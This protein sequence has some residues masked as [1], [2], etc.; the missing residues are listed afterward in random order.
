MSKLRVWMEPL[1]SRFAKND[2]SGIRRV[3]EAYYKYLPEFDIEFV[4]PSDSCDV[5]AIHAGMAGPECDV[6]H[7]HGLYW[8]ADYPAQSWEWKANRNVIQTLYHAKR[9]TVPS[10]WVAE[11]LQRDMRFTPHVVGHGIDWQAWQ[12]ND[13]YQKYVLW[14]KNRSADVCSPEPVS[15]LAERFPDINFVA[16]FASNGAPSNIQ[17]TGV[18]PHP[19]MKRLVQQ[20]GI[21]LATT[22]ETFGIGTLE[23]MA[24]GV[25]V[26]GFRWGGTA[27]LVQHGVNGYL[28]DPLDYDDLA[29]GLAY[30]MQ[31][32]DTLGQNGALLAQRY[33]WREVAAQLADIY[34]LAAVTEPP[35]V[36]VIVPVYNKSEAALL[37][38]VK[39]ALAQTYD[40]L[41]RIIVIDD[42]STNG[43]DYEKALRELHDGSV[44]YQ[45]KH[46]GGVAEARNFGIGLTD[47]KYICCLDADDAIE[48]AF[49]ETCVKAL[50][51]DRTLG[52]AYTALKWVKPD[53]SEGIS[54]WPGEYDYNEQLKRK[55]QVPC[56]CVYKRE[57]WS[58]LGGYKGRYCPRGA[59]TEDAEFWT[60]AGA[61]GY[62]AERV[63]AEPLFVY[64]WQNPESTTRQEG[65]YEVDWLAWHPWVND[66][67]HPL[68]SVATPPRFAHPVREYD[69][70]E[71]SVIIPV[72]P[73]HETHVR[74]ALDSLEAQ[75]FRNW[76]AIVVYD[77]AKA[78]NFTATAYPYTHII[79]LDENHGA[80]Y[81]RNRGAEKARAK[82]LLFLDADDILLP[83]A[84][85]AM[86]DT[87]DVTQ[88]A[89]YTDHLGAAIIDDISA[90]TEGERGNVTFWDNKTGEI[91]FKRRALDFDCD[92]AAL[93]PD[94]KAPYIW[95]NITTLHPRKW[96]KEL[97][98]FDEKMPSW[99][100]WDYW[101]RM[102][103]A[104][105][106]FTR[107]TEPLMTY[108]YYTG[109]RR[110]WACPDTKEGLHNAQQLF[111]YI[112]EKREGSDIMC[113]SCGKRAAQNLRTMPAPSAVSATAS[114][115]VNGAID[116]NDENY[117][118]IEYMSGNIGQVPVVG[119]DT[120]QKY[121]YRSHGERFLVHRFDI[122]RQPDLFIPVILRKPAEHEAEPEV[123]AETPAPH[124][125][126]M[127][128]ITF[129][130]N[131]APKRTRASRQAAAI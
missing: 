19:Q 93:Q 79:A 76:E 90:L 17:T 40:K 36:S 61:Y 22:K 107:V 47:T 48:P 78:D 1:L 98:G 94:T 64:S 96:W 73:G 32:R 55:N 65:Y 117:I 100:D 56:C 37:R 74:S 38:A 25:P 131:P 81:A 77:G 54:A 13:D 85:R 43:V 52:I 14:N 83:G 129:T 110:Q 106:C 45:K 31:Y 57:M 105:H 114:Y 11:T 87:W 119:A 101:L 99:E 39:S 127:G 41:T 58:R 115:A 7:L 49:I 122:E 28:A 53:G 124:Y 24:S 69:Q 2:E 123:K 66:G 121:G 102:A 6:S 4:G 42:G 27:E 46:N 88:N 60:R 62:R 44:T 59:G 109:E 72:G 12:H 8:T 112:T 3:A 84:L 130:E 23:A 126:D 116:Q 50:E 82:L 70:P 80:G 33:G 91:L 10:A 21:Y 86:L 9:V 67:M 35:T 125:I 34:R 51:K 113:G 104:G 16:T 29:E 30:C 95:C 103:W 63:T 18:I 75:T 15:R 111:A 26:L 20:A 5:K 97:G 120:R 128:A 89:V 71:I 92:R 118:L 108:R 68:A